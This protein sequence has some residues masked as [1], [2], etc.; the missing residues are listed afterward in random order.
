MSDTLD[1]NFESLVVA[2]QTAKQ[3]NAD[4]VLTPELALTGFHAGIADLAEPNALRA[5]LDEVSIVSERL[6]I[7]I[8][9]WPSYISWTAG[10]E[11]KVDYEQAAT[12][13]AR[14]LDC[15]IIQCNWANAIND[16]DQRGM[17][18]SIVVNPDGDI[19]DEASTDR[20]ELSVIKIPN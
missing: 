14:A 8:V 12:R 4:L 20:P 9:L 15:W 5:A 13:I 10:T 18:R 19:T 7:Q 16:P 2:L 17:G 3:A 11:S 6:D 1:G